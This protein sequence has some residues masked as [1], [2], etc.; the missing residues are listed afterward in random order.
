MQVRSWLNVNGVFVKLPENCE[1]TI[2]CSNCL[3]EKV[4]LY[5]ALGAEPHSVKV[6]TWCECCDQDT[7]LF[8]SD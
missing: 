2:N 5:V 8:D 4:D 7:V 6:F 1:M 3:A